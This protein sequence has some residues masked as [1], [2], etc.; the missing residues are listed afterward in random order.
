MRVRHWPPRQEALLYPAHRGVD[1]QHEHRE[2]EH[3]GEH[4]GDVEHAFR[5]LDEIAEPG[6]GAEILITNG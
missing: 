3:A 4:A 2:D 6:G 5:L 1:D